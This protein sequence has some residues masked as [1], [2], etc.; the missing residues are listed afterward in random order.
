MLELV[1]AQ[2]QFGRPFVMPPGAPPERIAA[3]RQAFVQALADKDLL[4]EANKMNLDIE[5]LSGTELQE[6]VSR[7]YATPAPIVKRAI[8][9]LVYNPPK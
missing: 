5:A 6:I 2:Q 7:I 4:A 9:A 8:G 1:Y 3:I